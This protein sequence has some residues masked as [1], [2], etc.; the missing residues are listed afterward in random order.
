MD[1]VADGETVDVDPCLHAVA[2]AQPRPDEAPT[3]IPEKLAIATEREPLRQSRPALHEH[4]HDGRRERH[5][6]P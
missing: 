4:G 6:A 3:G 2:L 1:D 5:A